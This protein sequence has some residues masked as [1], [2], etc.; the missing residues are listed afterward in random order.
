MEIKKRYLIVGLSAAV[1]G[2]AVWGMQ[3]FIEM[4]DWWG[5]MGLSMAMVGIILLVKYIRM[6]KDAEYGELVQMISQDERMQFLAGKAWQLAALLFIQI[7]AAA[8]IVC[9]ILGQD[10]LM[11][12][13]SCAICLLLILYRIAFAVVKRKY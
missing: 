3:M 8:V 12:M 10:E 9:K 13:A 11:Q 2:A 1:I 6:K 5:S 7:A 4:D